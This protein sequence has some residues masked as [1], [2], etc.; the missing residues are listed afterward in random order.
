MSGSTRAAIFAVDE[1]LQAGVGL[2]WAHVMQ[3]SLV[4]PRQRVD[5][6]FLRSIDMLRTLDPTCQPRGSPHNEAALLGIVDLAYSALV[7]PESRANGTR[8]QGREREAGTQAPFLFPTGL[9][10]F[11]GGSGIPSV[12]NQLRPRRSLFTVSLHLGHKALLLFSPP[13]TLVAPVDQIFPFR[14]GVRGV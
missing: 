6:A 10:D 8:A 13:H 11:S 5:W 3:P 2:F 9:A 7:E 4:I 1:M 14:H 12:A